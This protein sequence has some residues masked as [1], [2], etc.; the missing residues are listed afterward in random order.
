MPAFLSH[1]KTAAP[2]LHS[3]LVKAGG[4][5]GARAGS[6]AFMDAWHEATKS[7]PQRFADLQHGFIKK[8]HY[9]PATQKVDRIK[10]IDLARRSAAVK[11]A[12]WSAA[13]QHGETNAAKIFARALRGR[14]VKT[15][16]DREILHEVYTERSRV[17]TYFPSLSPAERKKIK[18]RFSREL[19]KALEMTKD[20]PPAPVIRLP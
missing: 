12:I 19:K 8:T 17:E 7:D 15:M 4:A 18:Q 13:V 5:D 9:D 6:K 14:D 2:D 20:Q 10:G 16:S 3:K 11:E 1:L